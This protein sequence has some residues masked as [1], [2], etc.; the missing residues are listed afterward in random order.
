MVGFDLS[1]KPVPKRRV[2]GDR[3]FSVMIGYDQQGS[4]PDSQVLELSKD[5]FARRL[6]QRRD[7]M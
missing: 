4:L 7:V 2:L 5:V 3:S 6:C 1:R